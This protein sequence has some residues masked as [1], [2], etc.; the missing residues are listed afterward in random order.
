MVRKKILLP[1][2]SAACLGSWDFLR[3]AGIFYFLYEIQE[4][5]F[6]ITFQTCFQIFP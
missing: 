4:E 1:R 6:L 2:G 3:L 5:R